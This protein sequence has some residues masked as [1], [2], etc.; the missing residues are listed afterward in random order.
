MDDRA[1]PTSA[2]GDPRSSRW[3]R[4]PARRRCDRDVGLVERDL[5]ALICSFRASMRRPFAVICCSSWRPRL[6]CRRSER[7]CDRPGSGASRPSARQRQHEQLY[8]P[9]VH[10]GTRVRRAVVLDEYVRARSL[11]SDHNK[12]VRQVTF[13]RKPREPSG[14]RPGDPNGGLR[15]VRRPGQPG[16]RRGIPGP[17]DL[18]DGPG[19]RLPD[20]PATRCHSLGS[21]PS[22]APTRV[23]S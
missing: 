13:G 23:V 7:G 11:V 17:G 10:V 21:Q 20:L 16:R 6:A 3:P 15:G 8:R 4:R 2:R 14:D 22:V 9:L 5:R 18:G 19:H 12:A 1:A